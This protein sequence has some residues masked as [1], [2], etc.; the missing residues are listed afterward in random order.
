M[1]YFL[2]GSFFPQV[3]LMAMTTPVSVELPVPGPADS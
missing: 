3:L 1:S 2:T